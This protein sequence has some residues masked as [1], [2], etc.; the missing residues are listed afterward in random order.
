ME[1]IPEEIWGDLGTI[2]YPGYRL[3]TLGQIQNVKTGHFLSAYLSDGYWRV[4]FTING[5]KSKELLHALLA[6]LF[7]HNPDPATLTTV[8]HKNRISTDNSVKNLQWASCRMQALNRNTWVNTGVA[9]VQG[10]SLVGDDV[11]CEYRNSY[12]A[13]RAMTTHN[14]SASHINKACRTG[15]VAYG[16]RWRRKLTPDLPGEIWEL[17]KIEGCNQEIYASTMGR[18]RRGID[19]VAWF[20][21]K[22]KSKNKS[23]YRTF[24]VSVNGKFVKMYVHVIIARTFLGP[25]NNR[26]VNHKDGK[27]GNNKIENLEHLTKSENS[28]HAYET[29]LARGTAV[30]KVDKNGKEIERFSTIAAAA[31][32]VGVKRDTL[33]HHVLY[34][35][36]LYLGFFWNH[37]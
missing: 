4:S 19:G 11:L 35:R 30:A 2:G 8:D 24:G 13:S 34:S 32:S 15:K 9:P 20:G 18:M 25:S 6:K 10:L 12:E 1:D 33:N 23:K 27:K 16:Y 37:V 22:P 17:A 5:V 3:S 36:K 7:V 21:C 28:L 14:A 29:G 31:R 26:I